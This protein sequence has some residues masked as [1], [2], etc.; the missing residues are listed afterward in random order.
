LELFSWTAESL[1]WQKIE[2]LPL[3]KKIVD[4]DATLKS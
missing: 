2:A 1:D 3:K 4:T